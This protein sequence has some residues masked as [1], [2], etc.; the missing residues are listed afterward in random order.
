MST[1][2]NNPLIDTFDLNQDINIIK[3]L[4]D[5]DK[6]LKPI[7]E[8]P[9]IIIPPSIPMIN[10]RQYIDTFNYRSQR[11]FGQLNLLIN[12]INSYNHN[13]LTQIGGADLSHLTSVQIPPCSV[14]EFYVSD[15]LIALLQQ[16]NNL[17][18]KLIARETAVTDKITEGLKRHNT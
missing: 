7:E 12:A 5:V 1:A 8:P 11:F 10:I 13:R 2:Y 17:Y 16:I 3:I 18:T 14:Y 4:D 6:S 9:P 15:E